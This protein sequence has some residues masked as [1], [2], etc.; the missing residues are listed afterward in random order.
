[1]LRALTNGPIATKG[2]MLDHH[3]VLVEDGWIADIVS[4]NDPR[5]RCGPAP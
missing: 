4:E 2:R 1:M 3:A 5:L